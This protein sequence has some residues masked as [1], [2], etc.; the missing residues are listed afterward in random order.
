M[1]SELSK[2]IISSIV[3]AAVILA[4]CTNASKFETSQKSKSDEKKSTAKGTQGEAVGKRQSLSAPEGVAAA[5]AE[6][7][8]RELS[9]EVLRLDFPPM[10]GQ[11]NWDI[12]EQ[13]GGYMMGYDEQLLELPIKTSWVLCS[14]AFNLSKEDLYYDDYMTLMFNKRVL[15]GTTGIVDMLEEDELGLPIYDWSRLQRKKPQ[16]S[17]TCLNGATKCDL[18]S[19][20]QSGSI[21][22][23]MNTETN[24]KLM[25]HALK[26]GRYDLEI[27]TTGDN[28]PNIDCA[29]TGVPLDVSIKYYVK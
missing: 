9:S 11:C 15:L 8:N 7:Q 29:H 2:C 13:E 23:E 14:M 25:T 16:G 5:I 24:L 6:C 20:Q 12:G 22:L 21:V 4:G 10:Q 17:S 19:T 28:D 27:V 26:A 3:F 18:T 1:F